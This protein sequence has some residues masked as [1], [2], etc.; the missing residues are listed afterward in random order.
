MIFVQGHADGRVHTDRFERG[1]LAFRANAA[2]RNDGM[3]GRVAQFLK[4]FQVCAGHGAFPVHIRAQKAGTKWFELR[5]YFFCLKGNTP[6]PAV[7]GDSPLQRV[8]RDDDALAVHFSIELPQKVQIHSSAKENSASDDDLA[9][10]PCGDS[11]CAGNRANSSADANF[12]FEFHASL[13]TERSDDFAVRAPSHGGVQVNY[14]Q[15]GVLAEFLQKAKD[16]GNGEFA[17]AAMYQLDGLPLLQ[18]DTR[19]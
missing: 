13:C 2:G 14:M 6:P 18:V 15:P 11:L 1:D 9:C 17:F 5:H 16:V 8:Q 12:H 10:S 7:Y 19:N 3:I 4:P